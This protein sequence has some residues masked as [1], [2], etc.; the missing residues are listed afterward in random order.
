MND[1]S[2]ASSYM[3]LEPMIIDLDRM[4]RIAFILAQRTSDD[5]T[6]IEL[7]YLAVYQITTMA[8]DLKKACLAGFEKTVG[9]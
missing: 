8:A 9:E 3:D 4:G 7:L 1:K 6:E 5:P 2:F